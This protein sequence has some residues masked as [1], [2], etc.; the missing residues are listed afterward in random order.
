M[1]NV[2]SEVTFELEKPG[3]DFVLLPRAFMGAL[4]DK[5]MGGCLGG[6]GVASRH[7][8]G[9]RAIW[10]VLIFGAREHKSLLQVPRVH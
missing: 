2:A 10:R 1:F 7:H 8:T 4:V 9:G 6:K 5:F 3:R